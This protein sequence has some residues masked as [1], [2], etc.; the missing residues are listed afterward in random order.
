MR[1]QYKYPSIENTSSL[2]F[3]ESYN[4][5]RTNICLAP[6]NRKYRK[7]V[8]TSSIPQEGKSTVAVNLA[9]SLRNAGFSV[10]LMDGD[11][12]RPTLH[13]L[14][15]ADTAACGLTDILQGYAAFGECVIH[16]EETGLDFLPAGPVPGNPAELIGSTEMVKLI[17]FASG[18]YDYILFDTP[19]VSVITDAAILSKFS[20]GVILVVRPNY[21]RV[22][23]ARSAKKNLVNV[24]ANVIG[25]VLN[26]GD[27]KRIRHA[28]AGYPF[29]RASCALKP[30]KPL[31]N[32]ESGSAKLPGGKVPL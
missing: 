30:A 10:L 12:R 29:R 13:K 16:L 23:F 4:S 8:I 20:D 25:T 11:L 3:M 18:Q 27:T 31:K 26:A 14:L 1:G 9:V 21:T 24:G 2:E 32:V 15:I 22:E 17:D 19:P 28:Y 6:S 7:I 5:L